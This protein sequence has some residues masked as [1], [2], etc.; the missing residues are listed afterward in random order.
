MTKK[1]Y[2]ATRLDHHDKLSFISDSPEKAVTELIW[3]LDLKGK[4]PA[5][6]VETADDNKHLIVYHNGSTW[7][8]D[9]EAVTYDC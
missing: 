8:M 3:F 1:L 7:S 2:K 4:D 5:V 9:T 6:R